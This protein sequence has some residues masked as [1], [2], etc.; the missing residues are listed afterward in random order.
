MKTI[1]VTMTVP[2]K[3]IDIA[4]KNRIKELEQEN[5]YLK[6]KL[7]KITDEALS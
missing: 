7:K 1:K 3:E 5:T 2:Q 6:N 4:I